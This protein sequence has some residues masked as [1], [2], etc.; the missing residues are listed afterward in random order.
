[1]ERYKKYIIIG[2]IVLVLIGVFCLAKL[3]VSNGR[4]TESI[5]KGKQ[6][7]EKIMAPEPSTEGSYVETPDGVQVY[8]GG[9]PEE[10]AIQSA[11]EFFMKMLPNMG[12]EGSDCEVKEVDDNTYCVY[13]GD[14]YIFV[15]YEYNICYNTAYYKTCDFTDEEKESILSVNPD[16]TFDETD[17]GKY[18]LGGV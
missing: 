13:S 18:K 15:T 5:A 16:I 6:E 3:L 4:S 11:S 7:D 12:F 14:W 8:N 10:K 2:L 1:M 9:S 17:D